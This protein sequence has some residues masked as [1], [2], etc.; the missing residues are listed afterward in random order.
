MP[1]EFYHKVTVENTPVKVKS[2]LD[3]P[4]DAKVTYKSPEIS[5]D[6]RTFKIKCH[7][8]NDSKLM[9]PGGLANLT[10]V[11]ETRSGLAVPT[12]ALVNRDNS[13]AIFIEENGKA[14]LVKVSVG[15]EN[16][17]FTEVT[18]SQLKI[19]DKVI[20]KGQHMVNDGTSV[21]VSNGAK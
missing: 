4:E 10:L 17:G 18:N 20:V 16:E 8:L 3:I 9:V 7:T 21:S 19:G 5:P 14:K 2:F 1:A 13:K 11:L 6:L 12:S 15:L